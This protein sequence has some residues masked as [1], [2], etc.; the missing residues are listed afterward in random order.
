MMRILKKI[1][2]YVLIGIM[3]IISFL[4]IM[5]FFQILIVTLMG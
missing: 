3:I 1:I 2:K 4:L 5:G